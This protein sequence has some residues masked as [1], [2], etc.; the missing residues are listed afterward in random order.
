[1]VLPERW[2][3]LVFLVPV[4]V[5][6]RSGS[7]GGCSSGVFVNA[8]LEAFECWCSCCSHSFLVDIPWFYF[9]S[10]FSSQFS[11]KSGVLRFWVYFFWFYFCFIFYFFFI[12]FC[13][14][15]HPYFTPFFFQLKSP[16]HQLSDDQG[17]QVRNLAPLGGDSKFPPVSLL[18][19]AECSAITSSCF[20]LA[21][22]QLSHWVS[23]SYSCLLLSTIAGSCVHLI[24][25]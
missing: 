4:W 5:A 16:K 1:M 8:L 7:I 3:H 2:A 6:W 9:C 21:R 13:S 15:S 22:M 17:Q 12:N 24:V 25:S 18:L 23:F 11:R 20:T 10:C 19:Y 14:L